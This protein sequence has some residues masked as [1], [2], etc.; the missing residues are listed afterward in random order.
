MEPQLREKPEKIAA[1]SC[2][3]FA[4]TQVC[5]IYKP[6]IQ[7]CYPLC[8]R[9]VHYYGEFY[10]RGFVFK[11]SNKFRNMIHPHFLL[12]AKTFPENPKPLGTPVDPI[13]LRPLTLPT[14]V[15][16]PPGVL[17]H[18]NFDFYPDELVI[19]VQL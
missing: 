3:F 8:Y 10:E 5:S 16:C 14:I 18:M 19:V 6:I 4:H 2:K 13:Y 1:V 7:Y 9:S 12:D 17:T 15:L 11:S